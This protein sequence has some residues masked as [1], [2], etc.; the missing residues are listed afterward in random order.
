MKCLLVSKRYLVRVI[1]VLL[2][3]PIASCVSSPTAVTYFN[4]L[5]RLQIGMTI[6]EAE[7]ILGHA[8]KEQ[9]GPS[10]FLDGKGNSTP[11]V[12]GKECYRWYLNGVEI[13]VGVEEGRICDIC[14]WLDWL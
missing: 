13:Y 5:F 9:S 10:D 11:V 14:Y 6:H 12:R 7:S 4:C 2:L 1:M 3:T 8:Q